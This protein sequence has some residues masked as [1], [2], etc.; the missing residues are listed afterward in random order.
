MRTEHYLFHLLG[1]ITESWVKFVD[2]KGISVS[3]YRFFATDRSKAMIL[4]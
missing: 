1:V 2:S 4:M 3:T